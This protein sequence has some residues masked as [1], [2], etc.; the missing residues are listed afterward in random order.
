MVFEHASDGEEAFQKVDAF[1][2]DLIFM[3]I[4]LLGENGLEITKKVKGKYPEVIIIILTNH[5]LPEYREAAYRYGANHF[6]PKSSSTP[7]EISGL[8]ET[9]LSDPQT[10]P[11]SPCSSKHLPIK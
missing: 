2:P 11:S 9:I 8:V 10:F 7:E 6:L 5:D 3:D 4:Q 1:G